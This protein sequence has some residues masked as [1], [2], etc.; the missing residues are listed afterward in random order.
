MFLLT[1]YN[2]TKNAAISPLKALD[3]LL[4]MDD[5]FFRPDCGCG[6]PASQTKVDADGASIDLEIPGVD[7]NTVE[8]SVAGNTVTFKGPLPARFG[9]AEGEKKEFA[10]SFEAPFNIDEEHVEAKYK[11]GILS[12]RIPK[13]KAAEARKIAIVQ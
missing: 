2:H 11:F 6:F 7:P 4:R 12:V 1:P 5:D 10:R 3:E 9:H 13:V 8:I